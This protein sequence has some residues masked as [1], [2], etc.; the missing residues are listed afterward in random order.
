MQLCQPVRFPSPPVCVR[1]RFA[2][3]APRVSSLRVLPHLGAWLWQTSKAL[4]QWIQRRS[5]AAHVLG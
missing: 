1:A 5:A 4:Q 3:A 2:A